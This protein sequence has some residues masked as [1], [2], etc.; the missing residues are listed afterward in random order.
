MEGRVIA[1]GPRGE[2]ATAVKIEP[3]PQPED[4]APTEREQH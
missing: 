2:A 4:A 1:Y 3:T